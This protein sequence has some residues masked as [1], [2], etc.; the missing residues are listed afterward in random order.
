[1][2]TYNVSIVIPIYNTGQYLKDTLTDLSNQ[3]IGFENIQVI[4]VNDGSTDNSAVICRQFQNEHIN[5][6]IYIEF[7]TNHGVSHARNVGLSKAEGKYITFW[8]SDDLWSLNAM[9]RAVSFLEKNEN[10]IDLV[11][12]NIEYFDGFHGPH[13]LNFGLEQDRIIDIHSDYQKIRSTG[14]VSVIK[15]AVAKAYCFD[16]DQSCWEDTKFLNQIILRRQRYGMLADVVYYYRRRKNNNSAS[17]LYTRNKKYYLHDL[18][19][20]FE[21]VYRESIKQCGKFVPMMQYLM[22]YAIGY[23]F[24]EGVTILDGAELKKYHEI[25]RSC[26]SLIEDRYLKEITN[27]DEI[28]K[29][30]MLSFKYNI[31]TRTQ[32]EFWKKREKNRNNLYFRIERMSANYNVLKKW[33]ELK[34]QGK[35]ITDFFHDNHYKK[36]IIY[37]MSD[38]GIYLTRELSGS[39]V[40]VVCG[41]DRRAGELETGIRTLTMEDDLP[42][43]DAIIITAVYFFDQ[44]EEELRKKTDCP[45]LSMEDV[46]FTIE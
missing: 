3:S 14:P 43:T 42:D 33:F 16:T 29:W 13:Q 41:I 4:L 8:D 15:T 1:M 28:V 7:S 6:V 11:S 24:A 21:G 2:N 20:L 26:L 36:I 19:A 10:E 9:E 22:S 25:L 39:D 31:D 30:E 44:I 34:Q 23:R 17:Q 27:V 46:V 32:M 38:L 5:N 40:E 45:I 35:Q 18:E 37:G 12:A